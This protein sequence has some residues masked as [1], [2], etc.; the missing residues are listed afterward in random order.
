MRSTD[1]VLAFWDGVWNAHDTDAVDRFAVDD[2]LI[3]SGGHEN[4][5]TSPSGKSVR[6]P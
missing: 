5:L 2:L 4:A 1:I 6:K 3:V